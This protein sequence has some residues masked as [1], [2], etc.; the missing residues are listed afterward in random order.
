MKIREFF[1]I[2]KPKISYKQKFSGRILCLMID[3]I[4]TFFLLF[5]KEIYRKMLAK[6]SNE[7][8]KEPRDPS[9]YEHE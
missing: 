9:Q 3:T 4:L 1:E 2:L 6:L 8:L 7:I 5:E